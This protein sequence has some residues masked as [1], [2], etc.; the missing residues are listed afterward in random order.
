[1][2]LIKCKE[3]GKQ[4]SDK[5]Q[6]CPH[7]GC[8]VEVNQARSNEII[9]PA[10]KKKRWPFLVFG[11]LAVSIVAAVALYKSEDGVSSLFG[12]DE[13]VKVMITPEFTEAVRKYDKLAAFSD[14]MA[15]VCKNGKWGY[16]NHKGEEVIPCQFDSEGEYNQVMAEH[17]D[18]NSCVS[19][20]FHEGVAL[21]RRNEEWGVI[22]KEGKVVVEYGKYDFLEDC[23]DG[24][25]CASNE[26][27]DSA[28][29]FN[30]NGEKQFKLDID[31]YICSTFS[32]GL[33][34]V[35]KE[36][37]YGYVNVKGEVTIPCK[38]VYA[39]PFSEGKAIVRLE[40]AESGL[41]CIDKQGKE[42]FRIQDDVCDIGE[43]HD[44]MLAVYTDDGGFASA[45]GFIDETGKLVIPCDYFGYFERRDISGVYPFS[46]GYT[47]LGKDGGQPHFVDKKGVATSFP[48]KLMVRPSNSVGVFSDGLAC[49]E[50]EN[51]KVGFMDVNGK[52]TIPF[53]YGSYNGELGN[54]STYG[55]FN[56]GV[57]LVQIGDC[58]G[59]VDKNGNDT[60]TPE[61]AEAWEA[62][63]KQEAEE[64]WLQ[65]Q[66][67]AEERQRE[68]EHQQEQEAKS[69]LEGN[70][71]FRTTVYGS[72][73]EMRVGI[74]GDV[75]VVLI[76]GRQI[77]A[78]PYTIEGN[79]LVYNRSNGVAEILIIDREN[80]RLMADDTHPMQRFNSSVSSQGCR[81]SNYGSSSSTDR[82]IASGEKYVQ[83]TFAELSSMASSISSNRQISN[84]NLNPA[85][86][87][88]LKTNLDNKLD[89][90]ASLYRKNGNMDKY[91][92]CLY[93]KQKA[94]RIF[95]EIG[96]N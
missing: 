18:E 66:R 29:F 42:L 76:D 20:A 5:A 31:E 88:M 33:L 87:M 7:C 91:N 4:I 74:S 13:A 53:K 22:D 3:C 24:I 23:H 40:D 56:N 21:V 46:E 67:E 71:R 12:G 65:E 47:Y 95:R 50:N 27:G 11:L 44:G 83:E 84:P 49:V 16:I 80:R 77:Y 15:A 52:L 39:A 86:L 60:F 8:P 81:H 38:Y 63:L 25:I 59:Y 68:L 93:K 69:W 45:Y 19:H 1:M 72:E 62:K 58:W 85:Y 96:L 41:R 36:G 78:G 34:P 14:G 28:V 73:T 90:L 55:V 51:G 9:E 89:E 92:E 75:I 17:I 37:K 48:Y 6:K 70:W 32:E 57:A 61:D 94:A 54:L 82:I 30:K 43:F 10:T 79:H 64:R 26:D 2:A 35:R